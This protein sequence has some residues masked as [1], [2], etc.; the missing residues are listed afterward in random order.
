MF[1]NG[2]QYNSKIFYNV[3]VNSFFTENKQ[4]TRFFCTMYFV[5]FSSQQ[6]GKTCGLSLLVVDS[7]N[8][9]SGSV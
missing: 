6:L 3:I 9:G 1:Y 4:K 2:Q 8:L 7:K 5:V